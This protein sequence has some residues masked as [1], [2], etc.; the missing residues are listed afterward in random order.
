VPHP[1]SKPPFEFTGGHLSLN[2]TNTVDNRKSS[3]R[4]ELLTSYAT[5]LQWA[6]EAGV[7]KAKAAARL[8][9]T[10]EEAPGQAKSV[11][12]TA[13]QLREALY[14]LFS[15]A[16]QRRAI[17]GR[18]LSIL[19]AAVQRAAKRARIAE[20]NRCFRWEFSPPEGSLDSVLW[21]VAQS[22][23]DLLTSPDLANVRQCASTDCAW[24]FLDTTK[25]HRRRWCEMKTCGNRAK[26]RRYYQRQKRELS[27]RD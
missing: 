14:A 13:V 24:L 23:A 26:A 4:K 11:L 15:A 22:A 8:E 5:L 3:H 19:N 17:P 21:P 20:R 25:N 1:N 2:F 7:L 12:R 16:T 9:K 10:A 6:E 27:I 18:A